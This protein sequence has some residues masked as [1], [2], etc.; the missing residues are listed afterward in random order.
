MTLPQ[1]LQYNLVYLQL[2]LL[3]LLITQL[4]Y[5]INLFIFDFLFIEEQ[6][7]E[8]LGTVDDLVVGVFAED[9]VDDAKATQ[10]Q[11]D[12]RCCQEFVLLVGLADYFNG[13]VYVLDALYPLLQI[14]QHHQ[15]SPNLYHALTLYL[16]HNH[17]HGVVVLPD[18]IND[19]VDQILQGASVEVVVLEDAD[20]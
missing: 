17:F 8:V 5:H 9:E 6:S 10:F 11:D 12:V 1:H 19:V 15:T 14:T 20:D 2:N 16:T 3:P 13:F 18:R 7:D 4:P